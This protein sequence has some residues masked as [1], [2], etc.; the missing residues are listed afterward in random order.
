MNKRNFCVVAVMGVSLVGGVSA[1]HA[2]A[3]DRYLAM[4]SQFQL[5]DGESIAVNRGAETKGYRI[6]MDDAP[7]A[8]PLKVKFE[9]KEILVAPGECR[10]VESKSV[11]LSSAGRLDDGM[12]LV[13]K[14]NGDATSDGAGMRVAQVAREQ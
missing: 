1:A 13:G 7:H 12:A 3:A 6:C 9:G 8:V 2:D 14:F 11:K 10:L 5:D 4:K